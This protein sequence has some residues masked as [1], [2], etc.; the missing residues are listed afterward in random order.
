MVI[1]ATGTGKT[2]LGAFDVKDAKPKKMLFLAHREQ[3]LEKSKNSFYKVLGGQKEDYG[4]YTGNSRDEDAKYVFATVQ[5]LSKKDHLLSF[6]KDEFDYILIDEVHHA[7]AETY[8]RI[9]KYFRPKFYL[10]MTATP[11]QNDDFNV[12]KLFDY[13]IAYERRLPQALKENMVCP[14]HYVGISDYEFQDKKVNQEINRYN[15][16][17]TSKKN[18]QQVVKWLSSKERVQYILE[19]TNYY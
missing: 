4:L 16:G 6:S 14:F 17:T 19:Q 11:E 13:N 15:N 10:G 7:G 8:Q 2:Y 9:M 18:T 5:T 3:I 1:S 12:F